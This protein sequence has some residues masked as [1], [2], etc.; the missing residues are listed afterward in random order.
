MRR[1]RPPE[2]DTSSDEDRPSKTRVKQAMLD[3]QDLA[4]DLL[5][6]P[7]DQLDAIDMEERM[8]H[9]FAELRRITAH[10]ARKRQ[11]QYVAKLLRSE[12]T[13]PF[14]SALSAYRA[15]RR[16]DAKALHEVERWRE[17]LLADPAADAQWFA[18]CP[19]ADTPQFR[20]L[21]GLARGEA[22]G[23]GGDAHG[24]HYRELFRALREALRGPSKD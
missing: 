21:I 4:R 14:R 24:R 7:Q 5:E 2:P 10:G 8:R 22:A 9:A 20:R 23:A 13:E 1:N 18:H 3:L 6:L 17:R 19:H 11:M 15:G 16:S 12:N